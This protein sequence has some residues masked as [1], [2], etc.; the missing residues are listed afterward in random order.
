ML[1][2]DHVCGCDGHFL[3]RS[4]IPEG[5]RAMDLTRRIRVV[6]APQKLE[7]CSVFHMIVPF[8]L[9]SDIFIVMVV[10]TAPHSYLLDDSL[11]R[12][13]YS[14]AACGKVSTPVYVIVGS[15]CEWYS[16]HML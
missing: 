8:D 7:G 11:Q 16:E 9:Y 2:E 1:S 13:S 6:R 4:V 15:C 12:N 5:V 3:F 14:P 10:N